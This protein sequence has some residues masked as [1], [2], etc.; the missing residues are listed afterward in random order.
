MY[1]AENLGDGTNVQVKRGTE[2][3]SLYRIDTAIARIDV[4]KAQG[5]SGIQTLPYNQIVSDSNAP[6]YNLNGVMMDANS[7]QKGI[8]IKQ[9]KKFVVK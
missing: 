4:F 8:Y 3:F 6:I 2:T 1:K 7:L 5:T 9:G